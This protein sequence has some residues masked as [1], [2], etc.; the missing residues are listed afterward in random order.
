MP[1][2]VL[3]DAIRPGAYIVS[4]AN[5]SRSREVVV[6]AG[7]VA[8]DYNPG[9]VLGQITASKKFTILTPGATD[10]SQNAAAIYYGF[11]DALANG[12]LR[13]AAHVRDME[14][15]GLFLT[16]PAGITAP[17]LSAAMAALTALGILVRT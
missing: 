6:I 13:A 11:G 2:T 16:W 7:G 10:G 9:T 15:N 17:Q 3:N 8:A 12:D 14:A 5:A 4:E 1:T